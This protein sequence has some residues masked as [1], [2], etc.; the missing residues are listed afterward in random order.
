MEVYILDE[1]WLLLQA[2]LSPH[3]LIGELRAVRHF[4]RSPRRLMSEL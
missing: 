1:F 3:F 2:N 4:V